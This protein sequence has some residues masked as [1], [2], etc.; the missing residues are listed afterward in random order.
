MFSNGRCQEVKWEMKGYPFQFELRV[1]ELGVYYMVLGVDWI[2][3][4]RDF[5]YPFSGITLF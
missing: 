5:A 4:D 2:D 1:R 3:P